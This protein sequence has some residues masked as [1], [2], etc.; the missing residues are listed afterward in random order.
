VIIEYHRPVEIS[1][2]LKLLSR[3]NPVTVP[4]GGGSYL[5][6]HSPEACAVVDLQ[7]LG[8]NKIY[9]HGKEISLGAA[10]TLQQILDDKTPFQ[11]MLRV[12]LKREANLNQRNIASLAGAISTADG[13]SPLASVLIA[14]DAKLH[15][16]PQGQNTSVEEWLILRNNSKPGLLIDQIIL[17]IAPQV[18]FETISRTPADRPI[19]IVVLACWSSGR[20]RAVVGGFGSLPLL[21]YDGEIPTDIETAVEKACSDAGDTWAS[22]EYRKTT[23][24][25]LAQRILNRCESV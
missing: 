12:S 22:A 17:S 2:A 21:A 20:K 9:R 19:V 24:K 7:S 8:L 18:Y 6:Q 5:T 15:W 4:L 13:R 11:D 23:A 3:K 10:V 14:L 1:E 25:I 16:L